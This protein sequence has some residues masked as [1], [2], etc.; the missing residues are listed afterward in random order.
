METTPS[1]SN[2]V[3]A[4]PF[5]AAT[6]WEPA[7]EFSRLRAERPVARVRLPSGDQAW[8]VTGY[9]ENKQVLGDP[10]FSRAAAT[11]PGA[12]R[13]QPVPPDPNSLLS[14]D[15]PEHSRLRRLVSRAF[16]ARRMAALRA[17]I[18]DA[19]ADLVDALESRGPTADLVSALAM[20]LPIGVICDLLGVPRSERSRFQ[21]LADAVLSLTAHSTEEVRAAREELNEYFLHLVM[22]KGQEP[23]DDLMS[24]LVCAQRESESLSVDELVALGRTLLTAGFHT[25]ANQIALA[26]LFLLR[27]PDRLRDLAASPALIEPMV[28]ELLR[29]NPLTVGGGLIRIATA[30]IEVGGVLVRAGEGVLPAIGSANMDDLVFADPAEFRPGRPQAH[31]A[32]GHGAHYCLGAMLARTEL[33]AALAA[34]A[35][36]LPEMRLA[37]PLEELRFTTG[38]LFRGLAELPV[39]W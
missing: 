29:L 11:A 24:E 27:H 1:A 26:S 33:R 7:A 25:T 4:F 15:P 5:S 9:A 36:S 13:L 8:L 10:R 16:S 20:P 6:P 39:A 14:M 12:P 32:F 22:V 17:R 35:R 34:L 30:D 23:G 38:R 19:A 18:D 21:F 31:I 3:I 2:E 37:V 28:E